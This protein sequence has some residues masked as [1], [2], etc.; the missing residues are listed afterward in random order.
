MIVGGDDCGGFYLPCL[1]SDWGTGAGHGRSGADLSQ[2]SRTG[3]RFKH[4]ATS[5]GYGKKS[6]AVE[7][8][9]RE[10]GK[11]HNERG[12]CRARITA[13]PK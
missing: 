10:K 6:V 12:A 2:G 13:V 5:P 9:R 7:R 3:G 1:R 4:Q 8:M 11:E